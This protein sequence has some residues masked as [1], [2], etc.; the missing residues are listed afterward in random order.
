MILEN[1]FERYLGNER[2]DRRVEEILEA[3]ERALQSRRKAEN[4]AKILI[5]PEFVPC[6]KTVR[7]RD[8]LCDL[9]VQP[10]GYCIQPEEGIFIELQMQFSIRMAGSGK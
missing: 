9:S 4:E 3:H 10:G 7:D 1:K 2:A 8:H 5:L 6:Q